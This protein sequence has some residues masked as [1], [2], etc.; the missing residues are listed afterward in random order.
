MI[1]RVTVRLRLG[2]DH[3]RQINA[4]IFLWGRTGIS[5]ENVSS[6]FDLQPPD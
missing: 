3:G 1:T 6:F 2:I 4:M 5:G